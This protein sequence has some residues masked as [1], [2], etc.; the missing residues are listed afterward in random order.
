MSEQPVPIKSKRWSSDC[1]QLLRDDRVVGFAM[2]TMAGNWLLTNTEDRVL[3]KI[4][5]ETI[6]QVVAAAERRNLG[7]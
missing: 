6:K 5:F 2:K 7:K 4:S 3:S 1:Y